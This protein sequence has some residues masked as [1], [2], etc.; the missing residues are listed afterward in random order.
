MVSALRAGRQAAI[1]RVTRPKRAHLVGVGVVTAVIAGIYAVFSLTLYYTFK[2]SAYDLTIFDQAVRSY[3][4]FQPGI[5][6][7]KGVHNGFGPHFSVLGDHFSPIIAV[8]APLYWIHNSP[9]TLLVAQGLLL[10][11]AIPSLWLFARRAFGGGAKAAAA[12]YFVAIAYGLSWPLAEAAAFDFHE[13]AFAPVLTAIALERF[14]AGRLRTALIALAAL[15]LVKEDMG[16]FVAGVGVWL[17]LTSRQRMVRRQWVVGIALVVVGVA[18]TAFAT[19]VLIPFFGGNGNYYW[20]YSALGNNVPQVIAHIIRHPASSFMTMFSHPQQRETLKYL[21]GAFGFLPL[22][23]PIFLVVIPLLVERMLNSQFPNWWVIAFQY[24]SYLVVPLVCAA[25]DGA[26]RLDR[27]ASRAWSFAA[28]RLG[29]APAP[30]LASASPAAAVPAA[31]PAAP[32]AGS[33]GPAAAEAAVPDQTVRPARTPWI[34]GTVALVGSAAMAAFAVY[35]V[36]N[37]PSEVP[38]LAKGSPLNPALHA[39]FYHRTPRENAAAAADARVPS[40]VSVQASQFLA[41]QLAERD[42]VLLWDGDGKH[43]PL[44]PQYVVASVVQRQF[45]FPN[46]AAQIANVRMYEQKGYTV[47]FRRNGYLVLRRPAKYDGRP[48]VPG[49]NPATETGAAG[50]A[51]LKETTR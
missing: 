50:R 43:R 39:S 18:W 25:V 17:A 32:A 49:Q 33:D 26:A 6:P 22:L 51:S 41:P 44:L 40:G 38:G 9:S 48:A 46:L 20:A 15:L 37:L 7:L 3:A 34:T 45:T 27:W 1:E 29:R 19:Y 13:A 28:A 2:T 8:L 14:Q 12:A 35:L 16:L 10:A 23:S 24:N 42:Y 21:L 36:P 47:I 31:D 5:S 30:A 11:L 4:H